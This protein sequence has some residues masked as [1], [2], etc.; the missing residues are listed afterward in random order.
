MIGL[1]DIRL[2]DLV[3]TKTLQEIQ[4]RFSAATGLAAFITDSD[5][6]SITSESNYTGFCNKMK[7]SVACG[8]KCKKCHKN[9]GTDAMSAGRGRVYCCHAGL[10]EAAAPIVV[11]G[12]FMG[13]F[14]AGQVLPEPADSMT[15]QRYA[16]DLG[17]SANEYLEAASSLNIVPEGQM[18]SYAD[19]LYTVADLL[20]SKAY[21]EYMKQIS[22]NGE[23][24][25][26][27]ANMVAR[28]SEVENLVQVNSDTLEKLRSEFSQLES[29]AGKS[30]SEVNSTKETVKVIQDVAMNTRILGFNAYIEAARAKEYGKS[31][32]VITQEIRDLADKSKESADKIEDAMGSI[33][34]FTTQIDTQIRNT[35]RLLSACVQNIEKFSMILNS[36]ISQ[37]E[38]KK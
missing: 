19:L 17:I 28:L 22:S 3:D 2:T 9:G 36:M 31:F 25:G 37:S 34:S 26:D 21:N 35:E 4:E 15:A 32:G 20:S 1:N 12:K 5:G 6:K 18:G 8:T 13:S 23:S 7:R 27:A 33:S 29:L 24:F 16:S 14:V 30:V 38:K 10:Y 11:N